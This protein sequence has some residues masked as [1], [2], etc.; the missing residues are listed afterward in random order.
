MNIESPCVEVDLPVFATSTTSSSSP[1]A[2][3]AIMVI[4]SSDGA[5]VSISSCA[6]MNGRGGVEHKLCINLN[7]EKGNVGMSNDKYFV[8]L[9]QRT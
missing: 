2:A 1:T 8:V 9:S 5:R 3:S 6:K 7:Y 4:V